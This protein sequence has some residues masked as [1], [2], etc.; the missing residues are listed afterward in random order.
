V[1]RTGEEKAIPFLRT[2][3]SKDDG[4]QETLLPKGQFLIKIF[5][6][7]IL[8]IVGSAILD[9]L[10]QYGNVLETE[11]HHNL[12]SHVN[13][14]D[15]QWGP[16]NGLALTGATAFSGIIKATARGQTL[17]NIARVAIALE[18]HRL[19][20]RSF[21]P[22]LDARA[23][24]FLPSI[25]TEVLDGAPLHYALKDDK[26]GFTLYSPVWKGTDDGGAMDYSKPDATNW[27]WSS[28]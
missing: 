9:S 25:P 19:R 26:Q 28:P 20:H 14:P 27:T 8:N 11:V 4:S 13:P 21:P 22:T 12:R 10:V 1:A 3:V 23:P 17:L 2:F 18:R 5:A 6:K 7:S 24:D 15:P 16:L